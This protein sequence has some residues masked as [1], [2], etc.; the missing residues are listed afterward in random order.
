M[1]RGCSNGTT[2]FYAFKYLSETD[3]LQI[4]NFVFYMTSFLSLARFPVSFL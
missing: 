4:L 1:E 3:Y 2:P